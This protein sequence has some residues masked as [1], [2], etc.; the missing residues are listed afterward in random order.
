MFMKYI[1]AFLS[2]TSYAIAITMHALRWNDSST[3][4]LDTALAWL[5]LSFAFSMACFGILL[6]ASFRDTTFFQRH[7]FKNSIVLLLAAIP[8]VTF[9][10]AMKF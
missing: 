9:V 2:I 3:D 5:I 8:P 7:P 10:F 1:T 4:M 6:V